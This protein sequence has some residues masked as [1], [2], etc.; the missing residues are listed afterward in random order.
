MSVNNISPTSFQR[1]GVKSL[2]SN[3]FML[4][5]FKKVCDEISYRMWSTKKAKNALKFFKKF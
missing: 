1:L 4:S 2:L 5:F 3:Q